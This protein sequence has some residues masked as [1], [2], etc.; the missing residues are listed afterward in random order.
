MNSWREFGIRTLVAKVLGFLRGPRRDAEC[1]DEIR[2]HLQLLAERFVAKG[3]SSEEAMAAARRQF[4]NVTLLQQDRRELQTFLSVEAWWQEVRYALRTLRKN[5]GF[6][7]VAVLTLALGIG[8][9]TAIF[10]LL[11]A[12]RLRAIPVK[13]PQQ[14]VTVSTGPDTRGIR[15]HQTS[16]YPVLTN[17]IWEKF[18][19]QQDLFSGVL[20]W[21]SNSF[22][23][24]PGGDVRLAQGLFV[25]GDFFHVL[26][27]RP[28]M[29]RVFNASDDRR[30]CGLPGA[31]VSY[32]FWQREL[33]G[34]PS[35]IGHKLTLNYHPVEVIG[36]T[37]P[38]FFGLEVGSSYDVAVPICSQAVLWS[39][40]TWL[41]QGTVWWLNI[42]GRLKSGSTP[43]KANAQLAVISPGIFQATLPSNYPGENVKDYLK[44]KLAVAPAGSGV[45]WLRN[46][47]SESLS[48]LLGTAGLVLLIACANLAN[49]ML[50]R[51]TTRE[52]EFS[53]RFAI[54]ASRGR[55]I[56]HSMTESL[57]LALLGGALGLFLAGALSQVLVASLGTQGD[58]PFLDLKP[59]WRLL[60]FTFGLASLTCILFGLVPAL[61]ASRVSPAE[62]FKSAGR[63]VT[64]SRKRFGFRQ[65]LVVSQ[66]ALSLVLVVGALLFSGSL[67]NLLAVDAGFLQ[68]G[69][70]IADLDLFR[71][72]NVPYAG[73]VAFKQDLLQKIRALPGVV[74]AA[75]VDMLPLSGS[76][77][78]NSV[79]LEGTNPASGLDSWFSWTSDGYFK[80]MGIPLL[81]GRD[82]SPQDT[83]NSPKVAIVNQTFVR[84]LG[85]GMNPIGK[86]FRRQ[87]T[88]SEPEES[89]E[90]VGLVADTKYSSL[91]EEFGPIAFLTTFQESQ[92]DPFA[93]LVIR[94]AAPIAETGSNVRSLVAQASPLITLGFQ[95]YDTMVLE[96]L[97]RERLMAK[98]SGFFGLLAALIAA[99]GLYGVM[100]YLVAQRTNEFG[101]R[102]ALGAQRG[103][104][105]SLV[106]GNAGL[107][108]APGLVLGAFL[109]VAAAQAARAMLFG[110][111]PNDPG[112][113]VAAMVGLGFIALWASFFPA[114]RAMRV[115]PLV[116]LRYE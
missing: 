110:L 61:R 48:L 97:T 16:G 114:R 82:F 100:S 63:T 23:L 22:G 13:E 75:E 10:Q 28:L 80:A 14:L 67:R 9:N 12:V 17:P 84:K 45:S 104:V 1:E 36:V 30:G 65:G 44:F 113:L 77:S 51:A 60:A 103:N 64:A 56:R 116:A 92:P 85:L 69:A 66:V 78:T 111:K 32:A 2:Q 93:Q 24:T 58:A 21:G 25:S 20:A 33:G 5:L 6:T 53:V 79:W 46:Q 76:S 43:E 52:H 89:F 42:M 105:L 81:A 71:R 106:L 59:D 41:D 37:P 112:V 55:L 27:V 38:G 102:V 31:V 88:P 29:G 54:G 98:V 83:V 19:D 34:D 4:G 99:V 39:E 96:G 86:V 15:G 115:D 95:P 101:I 94:S 26:G 74:S 7:A 62:A 57:A 73:R 87:A 35:A 70:V 91:R 40:G 8:A 47:Y 107:L 90:I 109:S 18:R 3:M 50:A 108:L 11:D 72:L 49:L 68:K